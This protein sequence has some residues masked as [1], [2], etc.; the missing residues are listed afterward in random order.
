MKP[1][2]IE[3]GVPLPK[4]FKKE[5]HRPARVPSGLWGHW[6]ESQDPDYVVRETR[7]Y[8]LR[9]KHW[10]EID[11]ATDREWVL[12]WQNRTRED[13]LLM[14]ELRSGF[15]EHDKQ[16]IRVY[17]ERRATTPKQTLAVSSKGLPGYAGGATT[18][19]R[20]EKLRLDRIA[21]EVLGSAL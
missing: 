11:A 18:L 19:R 2:K 5:V 15:S 12:D 7:M 3:A 13:Y 9:A 1:I 17:L 8:A 21:N 14:A 4:A 16:G 6:Q 20:Y 10:R